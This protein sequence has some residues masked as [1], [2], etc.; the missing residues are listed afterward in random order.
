MK[1]HSDVIVI[2]GGI[3]GLGIAWRLAER[4]RRVRLLDPSPGTGASDVAAGMIA[5]VTEVAY[6]EEALVALHVES[7]G[8]WPAFSRA[9]EAAAGLPEGALGYRQ[10]GTLVVGLDGDDLRV[11]SELSAFQ[12]SLGLESVPLTSSECRLR[13]PG[14][15]PRIRGG[16]F[17]PGDH[18]VDNR[19]VTRAL[20]TA[21]AAGGVDFVPAAVTAVT[22]DNDAVTGVMTESGLLPAES[23]VVAAGAWSGALQG[24]PR[25]VVPPVR[26]V[27]GQIVRLQGDAESPVIDSP[28]RGLA[29]GRSIY[30]VPRAN[31]GLVVGATLEEQGF[32]T[33]VTAEGV[34]TLLEAAFAL[35]PGVDQM[36][37][38]E[39]NCG[40]RP[41]TPDNGPLLGPTALDG[42]ILAT[43]H[44][45]HGFLMLPLTV[46]AI[47]QVVVT[48]AL[49]PQ[50]A[51]AS[52]T[53]FAGAGIGTRLSSSGVGA[54]PEV[55]R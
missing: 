12:Q 27:K 45:R 20:L 15:S 47:E 38:A 48:G 32:D 2:G 26:P 53:R 4:G 52:A 46:D 23:V 40:L 10:G 55:T 6:G 31:G 34:R 54:S 36:H 17:V 13:E 51:P 7:A 9:I 44:Y 21:C 1:D 50:Y 41:G 18:Y 28:V 30:L 16:A 3:I 39:T 42:L 8:R 35:V 14:L 33:R 25:E 37:L 11:V 24:L 43:G 29:D 5:P 19:A 22:C 49:A